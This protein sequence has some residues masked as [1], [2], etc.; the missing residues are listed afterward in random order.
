MANEAWLAPW[1][2]TSADSW[3][4]RHTASSWPSV[5]SSLRRL[6]RAGVVLPFIVTYDDQ[7]VGQLTVNNVVRGALRSA[8]IGYWVDRRHAG[9]GIITT[10]VA[11]ATD[12][13]FGPVGLHR[14]EIDIRPE[15]G[16][17]RRVVEKLGFREEGYRVRYLDIAGAW[18]DH[19]TYGMTEEEVRGGLLRRLRGRTSR[20]DGPGDLPRR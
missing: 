17:S 2:P 4:S 20:P 15:N 5:V 11:L 9:R 16:P 13:C 6:A 8:Q 12:H 18:R 7:L 1:E 3:A 10:A 14:I 19:I